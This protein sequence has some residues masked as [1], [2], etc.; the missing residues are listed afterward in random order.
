MKIKFWNQ[1][2]ALA[3]VMAICLN[4]STASTQ[5]AKKVKPGFR[6][7]FQKEKPKQKKEENKPEPV[8][9]E[10][11]K[12]WF[13]RNPGEERKKLQEEPTGGGA[14]KEKTGG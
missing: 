5:A 3:V 7:I 12:G 6:S 13:S 1:L 2:V 8:K 10:A 14:K 4:P 9:K 11:K